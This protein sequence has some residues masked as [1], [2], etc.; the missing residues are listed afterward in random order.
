MTAI[1][2]AGARVPPRNAAGRG[3]SVSRDRRHVVR[4][5]ARG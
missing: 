2:A 5:H 4:G 3:A 1:R